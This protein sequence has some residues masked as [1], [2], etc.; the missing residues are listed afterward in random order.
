MKKAETGSTLYIKELEEK[1]ID[2]SLRL[3]SRTNELNLAREKNKKTI[4]KLVHNLKN[5]VGIIYSFSD[6]ILED[7]EDTSIDK[8]EK[9]LQVI[10]KSADFSIQVLNS[11]AKYFQLEGLD[12]TFNFKNID[13]SELVNNVLNEFK[14][15]AE[16]KGITI[17]RNFSGKSIFLT[18][19]RDKIS[20]TIRNIINNSIRFS[21]ENSKI[22]ITVIENLKTIE[23]TITDEGIGISKTDLPNIFNAFY[24]VN[25]YSEDKQ[26]CIGL[27]LTIAK[28][29]IQ[30]HKG[31]ITVTSTINKGTN[32]E[33][34]LSK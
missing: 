11:I 10:K 32:V 2:L 20:L 18:A 29:V 21:K 3:K 17:E 28:E 14:S 25:T 33:M 26:K 13:Y 4:G 31:K 12:S 8:L 34:I 9:Y 5:P 1:I 7:I 27:G 6:M 22:K 24:V 16:E 23:T 19:D 15:I 30:H